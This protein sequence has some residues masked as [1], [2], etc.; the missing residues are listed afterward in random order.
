MV[1]AIEKLARDS[2]LAEDRF[3]QKF[4]SREPASV[5]DAF[6]YAW[7]TLIIQDRRSLDKAQK[8]QRE[9]ERYLAIYHDDSSPEFSR[10]RFL[11]TG[12]HAL[13]DPGIFRMAERLESRFPDSW[14]VK[15]KHID[16][17]LGLRTPESMK[18]ALEMATSFISRYPEK[19]RMRASRAVIA[20]ELAKVTKKKKDAIFAKNLI[21]E[22][23]QHGDFSEY[24]KQVVTTT[25]LAQLEEII[26]AS[27]Q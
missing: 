10:V 26:K 19:T 13:S 3:N 2:Q 16:F 9:A 27:S 7:L 25:V 4:G 15:A 24:Q 12:W 21:Q 22:C 14:R 23:L 6:E 18:T 20:A 8:S 17:L 1:P 5:E 11:L